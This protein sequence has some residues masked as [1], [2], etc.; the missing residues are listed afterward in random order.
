MKLN[1][2]SL[3]FIGMMILIYLALIFSV[4]SIFTMS[5][6]ELQAQTEYIQGNQ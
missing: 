3:K 1:K 5:D 2:E 4:Y 6:E